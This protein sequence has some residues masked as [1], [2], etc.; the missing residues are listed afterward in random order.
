MGGEGGR[1]GIK[2]RGYGGVL[3]GRGRKG[4]RERKKQRGGVKGGRERRAGGEE[5][6]GITFD[7]NIVPM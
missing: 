4:G 7:I 3:W 6:V 2:R 1:G 5:C